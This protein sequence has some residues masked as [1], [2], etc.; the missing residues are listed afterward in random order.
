MSKE[1]Y[2]ANTGRF[3]GKRF[4]PWRDRSIIHGTHRSRWVPRVF[5]SQPQ[6]TIPRENRTHT[7][8]ACIY[9]VVSIVAYLNI[10]YTRAR[11]RALGELLRL[12]WTILRLA[13][14]SIRWS[15]EDQLYRFVIIIAKRPSVIDDFR[16]IVGDGST[17]E[18]HSLCLLCFADNDHYAIVMAR[19]CRSTRSS[20]V[21]PP[22]PFYTR[23]YPRSTYRCINFSEDMTKR[24]NNLPGYLRTIDIDVWTLAHRCWRHCGEVVVVWSISAVPLRI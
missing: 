15:K 7:R 21:K 17:I 16:P 5:R 13:D 19:D 11:A 1:R 12:S 10:N 6:P 14:V 2:N 8:T 4:L 23:V 24:H 22:H 20:R 3:P 9:L 18:S